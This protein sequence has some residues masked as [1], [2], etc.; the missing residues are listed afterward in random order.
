MA[1]RAEVLRQTI[2]ARL[3]TGLFA[4]AL[5]AGCGG[6]KDGQPEAVSSATLAVPGTAGSGKAT[7]GGAA[8][9]VSGDRL[10]Q[11]F[12]EATVQDPPDDQWLPESGL[13]N[14]GKSVGK[15]YETV[16]AE[17]DKVPFVTP[18]G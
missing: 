4:A 8:N 10:H 3:A 13:T 6:K 1:M 14:T 5:L 9:V 7:N 16:V 18:A 17:W 11:S 15:L 2:I 12:K